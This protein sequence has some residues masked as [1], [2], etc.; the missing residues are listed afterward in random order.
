MRKSAIT[1][2][3]FVHST[4]QVALLGTE[5]RLN[6][7]LIY[8]YVL[9]HYFGGRRDSTLT[10]MIMS[11][12]LNSMGH[13]SVEWHRP[14]SWTYLRSAYVFDSYLI[15]ILCSTITSFT[16]RSPSKDIQTG[17]TG[18]VY[19]LSETCLKGSTTRRW[20]GSLFASTP[21]KMG[22]WAH[23]HLL[24]MRWVLISKTPPWIHYKLPHYRYILSKSYSPVFSYICIE[25]GWKSLGNRHRWRL[26]WRT[27]V[28]RIHHSR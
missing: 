27:K 20:L 21:T 16:G 2:A 1:D 5:V 9:T 3:L 23:F 26:P 7:E 19:W 17:L 22:E 12:L 25:V 13:C 10:S 6:L 15:Y 11:T 4:V 18:K 8:L 24:L 14:R 28:S